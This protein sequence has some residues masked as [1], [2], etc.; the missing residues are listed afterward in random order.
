MGRVWVACGTGARC[1][2]RARERNLR[3]AAV[4]NLVHVRVSPT[5]P[6]GAWAG[7]LHGVAT[8]SP[9]AQRM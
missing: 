8:F 3:G 5:T 6:C 4:L 9:A 2:V 7:M 1:P